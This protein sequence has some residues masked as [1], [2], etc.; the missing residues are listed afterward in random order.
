MKIFYCLI[1][2]M[3]LVNITHIP[4][5]QL[6]WFFWGWYQYWYIGHPWTDSR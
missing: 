1:A 5:D 3:F 6:I 4:R 2:M